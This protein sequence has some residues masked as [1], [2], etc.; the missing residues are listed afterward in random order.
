MSQDAKSPLADMVRHARAFLL[1][2]MVADA[3]ALRPD[4]PRAR[5]P[6]TPLAEKI[7]RVLVFHFENVL[8]GLCSPSIATIAKTAGC[9]D[10]SV[11]LLLVALCRTE[12]VTWKKGKRKR[13]LT[14]KGWR[15]VRASNRYRI[16]CPFAHLE[17]LRRLL[18]KVYGGRHGPLIQ[19]VVTR[20]TPP[21][22]EAKAVTQI[23]DTLATDLRPSPARTT[24]TDTSTQDTDP[25]SQAP[26]E[27]AEGLEIGGVRVDDPKLGSVLQGLWTALEKREQD[28]P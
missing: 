12:Y 27:A 10:S 25:P 2:A 22:E 23:V 14:R 15:V 13:V 7:F 5:G 8:T 21:S 17:A 20:F 9:A 3:I 1:M 24:Q 18:I 26:P 16:T 19:A 11:K 4:R 6:L 28:G